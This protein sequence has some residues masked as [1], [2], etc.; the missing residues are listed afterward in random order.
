MSK[1]TTNLLG[2]IIAIIAGTYFYITLCSECSSNQE[3][4]S[5]D[6]TVPNAGKKGLIK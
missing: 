6:T 3:N 5:A 2:I 4:T 1:K